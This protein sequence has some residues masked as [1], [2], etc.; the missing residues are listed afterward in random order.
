MD[1]WIYKNVHNGKYFV[2]Y[3][4][5]SNNDSDNLEEAEKYCD[6]VFLVGPHEYTRVPYKDE[7]RKNRKLK[8]KKL[9]NVQG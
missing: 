4:R 1:Y 6:N 2:P 5:R 9:E 3:Y 8:L 7:L